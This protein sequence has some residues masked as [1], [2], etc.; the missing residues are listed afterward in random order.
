MTLAAMRQRFLAIEHR[1]EIGRIQPQ[2]ETR[3]CAQLPLV[4]HSRQFRRP[5]RVRGS[6]VMI[7]Q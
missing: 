6:G 2:A 5:W 4:V 1:A 3:Q 7:V